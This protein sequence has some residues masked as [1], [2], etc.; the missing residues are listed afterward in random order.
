MLL[1]GFRR[2]VV[3]AQQV[4]DALV[5]DGLPVIETLGVAGQEDLDAVAGA[6]G[7]LG[8]VRAR[9]QPGGQRRVPQVVRAAR[10]RGA[11]EGG[12]QREGASFVPD[13]W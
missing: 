10:E 1:V 12:R 2:R 6:L 9:A 3:G 4:F 7:Y 5:V 8:R 13:R 11:G